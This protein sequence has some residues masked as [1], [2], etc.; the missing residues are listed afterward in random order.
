MLLRD[1]ITSAY[2]FMPNPGFQ[3]RVYCCPKPLVYVFG[4]N[5][6]GKTYC[7]VNIAAQIVVEHPFDSGYSY[8][9]T[10]MPDDRKDDYGNYV[11][12]LDKL[13]QFMPM[14]PG[15]T[16]HSKVS[17]SDW[18]RSQYAD[19]YTK[20]MRDE[21]G[22][23]YELPTLVWL[24]EYTRLL[25]RDLT[26]NHKGK[27]FLPA[28]L[29]GHI[30][31]P[32]MSDVHGVWEYVKLKNRSELSLKT[33]QA[34]IGAYAG[35]APSA[36]VLDELHPS[37]IVGESQARVLKTINGKLFYIFTPVV[38]QDARGQ[39][40]DTEGWRHIMWI[41][42][43][44][45][46]L[47]QDDDAMKINEIVHGVELQENIALSK[48]ER[49]RFTFG[50][51]HSGQSQELKRIR[52][53]GLLDI[54]DHLKSLDSAMLEELKARAIGNP[55]RPIEGYLDLANRFGVQG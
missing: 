36:I 29:Q 44:I 7:A 20:L 18:L 21:W 19:Y 53:K 39:V 35:P 37:S 3:M 40:I 17:R 9:P 26:M 10:L 38:Q 8:F 14:P 51:L 4:G 2:N 23:K 41:K 1:E 31:H 45:I 15:R 54:S 24:S 16:R 48:A 32:E 30:A 55:I 25:H 47:L 11:N 50:I 6:T 22:M 12:T 28:L 33:S 5:N 42:T 13:P 46:P 43:N 52:L 49:D 27:P 34:Q